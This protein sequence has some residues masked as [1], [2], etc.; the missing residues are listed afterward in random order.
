MCNFYGRNFPGRIGAYTHFLLFVPYGPDIANFRTTLWPYG[1]DPEWHIESSYGSNWIVLQEAAQLI[2]PPVFSS[3]D[4][5]S[6]PHSPSAMLQPTCRRHPR[7]PY[8]RQQ[9]PRPTF[10]ARL[11]LQRTSSLALPQRPVPF[12]LDFDLQ[13]PFFRIPPSRVL[14]S[15]RLQYRHFWTTSTQFVLRETPVTTFTFSLAFCFFMFLQSSPDIVCYGSVLF[16]VSVQ[17][18]LLCVLIWSL[19]GPH[20]ILF[21]FY[22]VFL[23]LGFIWWFFYLIGRQFASTRLGSISSALPLPVFRGKHGKLVD[24]FSHE[25]DVTPLQDLFTSRP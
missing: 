9:A 14:F 20:L 21:C 15:E 10:C 16:F 17:Y 25:L 8:C 3:N 2:T 13:E 7:R 11:T 19:N 5:S 1:R 18:L 4:Q 12:Q 23:L 24:N 6:T 22:V